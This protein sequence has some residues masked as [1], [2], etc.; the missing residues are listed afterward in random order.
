MKDGWI[1]RLIRELGRVGFHGALGVT[2]ILTISFVVVY[3]TLNAGQSEVL[4]GFTD[5]ALTVLTAGAGGL[6]AVAVQFFKGRSGS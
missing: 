3:G 5:R 2:T 6:M 4:D 1:E